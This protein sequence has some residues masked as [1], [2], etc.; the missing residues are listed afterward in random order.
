VCIRTAI[1]N[2]Y[3][4]VI[5]KDE[6]DI[7]MQMKEAERLRK[8]WEAKGNPACDHPY[9]DKEYIEGFHTGDYVCTTCGKSFTDFGRDELRRNKKI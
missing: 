6:S 5:I 3:K 7:N 4:K 9:L 2:C 1:Q 8:H